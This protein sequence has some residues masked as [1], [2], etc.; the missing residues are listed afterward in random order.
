MIQNSNT[1]SLKKLNNEALIRKESIE[2]S[3]SKPVVIVKHNRRYTTDQL[4]KA[5]TAIKFGMPIAK[6]SRAYNIPASTIRDHMKGNKRRVGRPS[7][8]T[9]AEQ[10]VISDTFSQI[11]SW[12][13]ELDYFEIRK[14]IKNYLDMNGKTVERFRNN[15]PGRDFVTSF[16]TRNNLR[17]RQAK[18]TLPSRPTRKMKAI[19]LA[20]DKECEYISDFYLRLEAVGDIE[21]E[22]LFNFGEIIIPIDP[23]MREVI[24]YRGTRKIELVKDHIKNSTH[25]SVM[26]CGSA[27]GEWLPPFVCYKSPHLCP[28]WTLGGPLGTIYSNTELGWFN[29]NTFQQWFECILLAYTKDRPGKKLVIGDSISSHFSP[30]LVQL[31]RQNS[32][33]FA[34]LSRKAFNLMQPLDHIFKSCETAWKAI[35]K[36]LDYTSTEII[37]KKE[38]QS[39][40]HH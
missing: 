20:I 11:L 1:T 21:R 19:K 14:I 7:E 10:N 5:L 2:I 33:C 40:N 17:N 16:M 30:H 35:L 8:L 38:N 22:N 24:Y 36:G 9:R 18:N 28:S 23:N 34:C 3:R 13:Y 4:Q 29:M 27:T 32:V 37:D 39:Q 26:I 25:V 6:A 31:A 15:Y 12:G